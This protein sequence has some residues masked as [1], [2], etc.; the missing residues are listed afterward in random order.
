MSKAMADSSRRFD[1]KQKTNRI[2]ELSRL[3]EKMPDNPA[4]LRLLKELIDGG[5]SS[6]ADGGARA[7]EGTA[8][9]EP[10]ALGGTGWDEPGARAVCR[11]TGGARA[12]AGES[13]GE[14]VDSGSWKGTEES[15]AGDRPAGRPRSRIG[16]SAS[17]G[18]LTQY[19]AHV[20]WREV[21]IRLM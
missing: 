14:L 21:F 1:E 2:G 10:R 5:E 3:L 7:A 11:A 13:T 15:M 12:E 4:I 19:E 6:A 17:T 9:S 8:G 20:V 16:G 18:T